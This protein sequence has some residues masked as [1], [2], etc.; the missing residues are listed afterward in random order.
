MTTTE[1]ATKLLPPAGAP[2]NLALAQLANS[3]GDGA[4]IV[5]SALFFTR[6]VG[7]ST[8]QV[9]L[10]LTIAWLVGFLTGVPLGH[11]ADRNGPRG[12]AILLAVSTAL[13]VGSFLVV[14]SFPLFL[15][16]AIAYASSQTGLT[17]ARQALLAGLVSPTERTRIRAFLQATVNAGLAVGAAL[18][19]VALHF[20]TKTAYLA[21]FTIDAVSFLIAA[22]LIHR[23]PPVAAVRIARAGEPR[24]AVLRDRPYAVLTLLNAVMLMFMPLLSLVAPLWIVERTNAPGWVVASLLVINTLGVTLF[25]VRIARSV[26]N[27]RTATRS[28]RFAGVAMLTACGVFALSAIGM[29]PAVTAVVL[30]AAAALLTFGEMKLASGAWEISFGLA[31]AE[32]QGQYQGFFGT[33]PAIARMLGPALLTTLVLGWGAAGW[34]VVGALFLGTSCVTGPAVRWAARTRSASKADQPTLVEEYAA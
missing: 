6:V 19:G 27:L 8:A 2:R 17:A 18:G 33:G 7:L 20:D 21:V 29:A 13:S 12:V 4:F 25:Q 14:R 9:G 15:I 23:V 5:T 28:V 22:A 31:P 3:I 30:A 11:L 34:M 1:R 16:A 26:T 32:Q 24:L 10:G